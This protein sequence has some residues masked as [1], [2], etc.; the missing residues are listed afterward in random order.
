VSDLVD[1]IGFWPHLTSLHLQQ[2]LLPLHEQPLEDLALENLPLEDQQLF[3]PVWETE[4]QRLLREMHHLQQLGMMDAGTFREQIQFTGESRTDELLLLQRSLHDI[5]VQNDAAI[6]E[7]GEA[8]DNEELLVGVLAI[9]EDLT[10][11]AKD[12]AKALANAL[13]SSR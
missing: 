2:A 9:N 4:L 11:P 5:I 1:A 7:A 6:L 13:S 12:A 8:E 10:M 3:P